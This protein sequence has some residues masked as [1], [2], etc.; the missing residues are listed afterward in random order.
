M[1]AYQGNWKPVVGALLKR[2]EH[3]LFGVTLT[4]ENIPSL[5]DAVNE[6]FRH[7]P[8]LSPFFVETNFHKSTSTPERDN[9]LGRVHVGTESSSLYYVEVYVLE[10]QAIYA[11]VFPA[12]RNREFLNRLD[13]ARHRLSYG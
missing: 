11:T 4:S 7:D 10:G 5:C 8:I 2:L 6:L 13:R 1:S 12:Q 3:D 9:L